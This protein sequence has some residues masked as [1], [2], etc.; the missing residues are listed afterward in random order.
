MNELE[1]ARTDINRID[2]EL[3]RLFEE[4]MHTVIRVADYKI[5]NNLSVFDAAR[6]AANIERTSALLE[7]PGLKEYFIKWYQ[8]L[9][10]TAKDYERAIIA[11]E[12]K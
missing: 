6:E 1:Q 12:T 10:D 2:N 8:A 11:K 5:R 9:M 3:V 4:R 7:D